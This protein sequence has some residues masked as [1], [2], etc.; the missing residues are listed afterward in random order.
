MCWKVANLVLIPNCR[1]IDKNLIKNFRPTSLLNTLSKVFETFI[2]NRLINEILVNMS[3]DQHG[4][5]KRKST[6]TAM[7]EI[8]TGLNLAKAGILLEHF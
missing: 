8:K 3:T 2:I 7:L 5:I 6:V 4:F 1:N